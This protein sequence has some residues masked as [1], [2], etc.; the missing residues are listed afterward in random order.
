MERDDFAD[1]ITHVRVGPL[2][3]T[4]ANGP[5]NPS[6]VDGSLHMTKSAHMHVSVTRI[7][8]G[9]VVSLNAGPND[10]A[11]AEVYYAEDLK[12]VGERIIALAVAN[13]LGSQQ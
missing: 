4:L 7:A 8:N 2:T 11:P 9:Y 3:K 5:L 10:Y 13:E 12:A 6:I 1:A